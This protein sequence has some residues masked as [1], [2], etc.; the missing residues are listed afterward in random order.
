MATEGDAAAQVRVAWWVVAAWDEPAMPDFLRFLE[1]LDV[2]A[3]VAEG[4]EPGIL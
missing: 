2:V 3:I 4:A 1:M